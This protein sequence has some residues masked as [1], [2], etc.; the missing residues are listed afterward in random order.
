MTREC[1]ILG[2]KL[3]FTVQSIQCIDL[4]GFSAIPMKDSHKICQVSIELQTGRLSLYFL[5]AF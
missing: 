1:N 3:K 5:F 4:I 2:P